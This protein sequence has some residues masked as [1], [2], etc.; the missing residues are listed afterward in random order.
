MLCASLTWGG[1]I[2]AYADDT[3]IVFFCRTWEGVRDKLRSGLTKVLNYLDTFQLRFNI[4]KT[5]YMAFSLTEANRP[6]F[7]RIH[8]EN[9]PEPLT[10]CDRI[11]YLGVFVDKHL[12]W[13]DH[14]LYSTK[15]IRCLIH[16]FYMLREI[17]SRKLLIAI[18][19]ALVE[20]LL[21]YGILV[22]GGAYGVHLEQLK[23]IQN[24]IVKI[25][26]KKPRMYPTHLLYSEI[27]NL[28]SLYILTVC[29]FIHLN[30]KYQDKYIA[31]SYQ[32]RANANGLFNVTLSKTSLGQH[33]VTYLGLKIYNEIPLNIRS[34]KNKKHFK[35]A[36]K[37]FFSVN[38]HVLLSAF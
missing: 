19:K 27:L 31:H 15:K 22:W 21:G 25:I 29:N 14:I 4:Q 23:R 35:S 2:I 8:L 34:I 11:K 30:N 10:P 12:K 28:K 36:L 32:T 37:K 38:S 5:Q 17:L 1:R 20:P 7:D 18:Y 26:F 13:N 9:L 33:F 24:Y 6:D 3:V 16:K